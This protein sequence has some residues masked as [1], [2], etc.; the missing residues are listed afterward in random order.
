M[1][2]PVFF[3]PS[4]RYSAVEVA[5]LTGARLVDPA[6]AG[7]EISGIASVT[8]GGDGMLVFVEG[9]R[10]A[11]LA[12]KLHAAAVL[13]APEMAEHMPSG[14]A[15][16]VA[17][18]PQAAFAMVGRML[19]PEAASP[20][21][22]TS[23]TG[24]SPRALVDP[25]A[26][27]E[28]GVIVEAG[29]IIGQ[30]AAI[31]SGT[32]IGPNA[33]V[34][35]SCQVGRDCYIGPSACVQYALLGDR[36]IVYGGAMIGQDGF[37]FVAGRSGPERMPQIGRVII[38]DN[39]EIG[40][41]TTIDRGA[42]ADTVIGEATKIDNLVQVAH[43]VRIGRGCLIA[44]HT[45]LSGSVTLGDGVLLGGRVG[46]S[47]HVAIGSGAQ[48]AAASGVMDDVPPGER[49]AGAPAMPM[50]DFFRQVIATKNL[51]KARKGDNHG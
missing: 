6:H 8:D 48:I 42:M 44:A 49:W 47:D 2:D 29:A 19:F 30:D 3:V 10:N 32:I 39:V 50:R 1:T 23:E 20:R 40:A 4:R 41:N 17:A 15:V 25:S 26:R 31:G 36:V 16:L 34:G 51:V 22:M 12:G 37:G 45:G 38:Q 18:R 11:T 33:I 21:A 14:L 43:N 7:I 46:I 13:C 24:V 9:K 27:L 35:R 28:A 5:N